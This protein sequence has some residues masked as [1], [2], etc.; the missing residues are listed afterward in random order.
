MTHKERIQAL[1]KEIFAKKEELRELRKEGL[2]Q[3]ISDYRF[4][5]KNGETV[6]LSECFGDKS[7]LLLV[8][9]MGKGCRYC[10][11][12]A[13]NINGISKPLADRAAFV[14]VSKDSYDVQAAFAESRGWEFNMLSHQGSGFALDMG[15][16]KEDGSQMPGVSS[17]KLEGGKII[18][19]HQSHFGPGDN[20]CN[21]WDFVDLLPKGINNWIPKYD[22]E[23]GD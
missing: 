21:L 3:K 8:Y 9:N 11:L 23:K 5:N 19:H 17:F 18:H 1:E 12:W 6:Q 4:T 14:V 16:A 13:D 20:Y 2:N 7:E 22:Y 15:M 10:T